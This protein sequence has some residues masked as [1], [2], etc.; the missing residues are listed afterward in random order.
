VWGNDH[1][2]RHGDIW[3]KKE[4]EGLEVRTAIGS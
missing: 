1:S 4:G 2:R 3:G